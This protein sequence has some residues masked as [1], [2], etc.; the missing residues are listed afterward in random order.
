MQYSW[1]VVHHPLG[2]EEILVCLP[3]DG[4]CTQGERRADEAEQRGLAL[5]LLAERIQRLA[6]KRHSLVGVVDW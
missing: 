6:Q 4:V 1:L 5:C 3:L 2:V